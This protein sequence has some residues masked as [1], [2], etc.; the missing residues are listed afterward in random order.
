MK[1]CPFCGGNDIVKYN[2]YHSCRT[3]RADGPIVSHD[4]DWNKRAEPT[5]TAA[6][7]SQSIIAENQIKMGKDVFVT[8]DKKTK[9][10]Y[11]PIFATDP[12]FI[13]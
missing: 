13:Q 4:Y 10:M 8:D 3:C 6:D 5:Y 12:G 1:P 7:L 2:S 11:Q 9:T